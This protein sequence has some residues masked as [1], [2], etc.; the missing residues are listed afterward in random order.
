MRYPVLFDRADRKA[1]RCLWRDR[2]AIGFIA[3]WV[4][5]FFNLDKIPAVVFIAEKIPLWAKILV[6][7]VF[8]SSVWYS[9][10]GINGNRGH[11]SIF[12]K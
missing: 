5:V 8:M 12:C 3:V 7:A 4:L 2:R 11:V 1:L 6:Y 10:R 9:L